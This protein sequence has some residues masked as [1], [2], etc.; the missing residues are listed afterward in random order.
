M[1][2]AAGYQEVCALAR[3][4]RSVKKEYII[5]MMMM[6]MIMIMIMIMM[7][8][9]S[10]DNDDDYDNNDNLLRMGS[11]VLPSV[12]DLDKKKYSGELFRPRFHN[13]KFIV[14]IC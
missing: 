12:S 6:I 11:P 1:C 9:T 3:A 8:M 10:N 13:P 7:T 5:M 2:E 14:K 4:A